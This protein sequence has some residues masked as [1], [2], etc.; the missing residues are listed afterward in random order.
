MFLHENADEFRQLVALAASFYDIT[1]DYVTKDYFAV[2][3]LK[4]VTALNPNLVFKGG[5]SLSKC[6]G[7][8]NR[9][10]EDVDLGLSVD[11]ATEG[12]RKDIKRAVV[13]ACQSLGLLIANIDE[14]RSRREFNRYR[15]C[16]E[17]PLRG[18]DN[19][20]LV[21]TAV[22]TPAA[23][24]QTRPIQSFIG[25]YCDSQGFSDAVSDYGLGEFLL[26]VSALE[27]TFCDKVFAVCDYYLAG[28]T[29]SRQSRHLYDLAK[30]LNYVALDDALLNLFETVREQRRGSYHT[31]SAQYDVKVSKVL[32][33]IIQRNIYKPDYE[34]RTIPLLYEV[35][36]YEEAAGS[37]E[38]IAEFLVANGF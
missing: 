6:F 10:S 17:A 7:V 16:F 27:K 5:T 14:I 13:S 31:P 3:L 30:L 1:T 37:L 15:I 35:I 4:E 11:H 26:T 24:T 9:F 29:T 18:S 25:M 12:M 33:E 32:D 2:Q 36:S 21:E 22:M 19:L 23:P 20:L 34:K 28:E 38:T 8:I